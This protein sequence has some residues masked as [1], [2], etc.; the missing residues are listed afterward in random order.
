MEQSSGIK[1]LWTHC[2]FVQALESRIY[3]NCN[4]LRIDNCYKIIKKKYEALLKSE[5]IFT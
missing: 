3:R 4:L 5:N 1:W 2:I